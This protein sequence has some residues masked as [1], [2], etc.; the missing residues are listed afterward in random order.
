MRKLSFRIRKQ[1]FDAIV[2]GEKLIEYRRD[3]PFWH[4]RLANVFSQEAIQGNFQLDPNLSGVEMEAVFICGKRIHRR[5]ITGIERIK[6][7]AWFSNQ[8]KH[9]VDTETCLAF[10]LGDATE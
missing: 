3:I 6:T 2:K 9:D 1:Y 7:P 10:H 4:V 5:E 8:G